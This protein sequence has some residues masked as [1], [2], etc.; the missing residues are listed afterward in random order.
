MLTRAPPSVLR[1]MAGANF[2]YV[3]M[4]DYRWGIF[5]AKPEEGRTIAFGDH[6]GELA[7]GKRCPWGIP[8]SLAPPDRHPGRYRARFR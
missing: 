4:P 1:P 2:G 5:L 8:Q 7:W 3:K 6:R